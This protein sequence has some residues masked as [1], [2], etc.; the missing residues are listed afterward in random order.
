MV[1][2]CTAR[3]AR[4]RGVVR[5]VF[6]VL[7][8]SQRVVSQEPGAPVLR[9]HR[10]AASFAYELVRFPTGEAMGLIESRFLV[11]RFDDWAIGPAVVGAISGNRGGLFVLGAELGWQHQ[12]TERLATVAGIFAG[13]GGGGSAP[14]GSGFMWRPFG[15]I[16]WKTGDIA[17]DILAS[18]VEIGHGLLSSTQLAVGLSVPTT[19]R[20][21]LHEQLDLPVPVR[22]RSGMGF[23]AL[24][25]IAT[26]YRP[27]G[28]TGRRSGG[29][30][31]TTLGLVG[32][33]AER[34]VGEHAGFALEGAGAA[35]G[36]VSG[37]AEYLVHG[38]WRTWVADDRASLGV[39]FGAG[40]AGGGD[41]DTGGGLLLK[42][43]LI[44][45]L[46]LGENASLNAE[47]G[48][49]AAPEGGFRA[50]TASASLAWRLDGAGASATPQHAVRTEWWMGAEQYEAARVAGGTRAVSNV[51]LRV[52]RFVTSTLYLTGQARSA[53]LGGAGGFS[54]GLLGAGVSVPFADGWRAGGEA[55]L[56][57]AG[58]GGISAGGGA[59]AQG[60]GFLERAL[61]DGT[62]VRVGTGYVRSLR[63]ALAAPLVDLSLGY[64]FGVT[65][66]GR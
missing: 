46:R 53:F 23:D 3:R 29:A 43:A 42:G 4:L 25:I 35:A 39:R 13:G 51:A 20:L 5:L 28:V 52:N 24:E 21:V 32:V 50:V 44:A 1:R 49:V 45:A 7:L 16:R 15:G 61:V 2:C 30:L 40:M 63:G 48:Y 9:E 60:H 56:G 58:G 38:W 26:I 65:R 55:L 59:V 27:I 37:Y 12:F 64:A 14:V 57:A 10:A 36:G 54:A 41:I 62:S 17:T 33:R 18:H 34:G 31:P 47:G 19:F 8:S 11:S 6:V 66:G 22:G